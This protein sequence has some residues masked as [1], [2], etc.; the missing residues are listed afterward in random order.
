MGQWLPNLSESSGL[1]RH[2]F[3]ERLFCNYRQSFFFLMGN[4]FQLQIQNRAPGGINI[5]YR[6][7][8]LEMLAD[9][10]ALQIQIRP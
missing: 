9:N 1:H 2:R 5:H 3:I 7:R 10:P 4:R 6:E 8:S